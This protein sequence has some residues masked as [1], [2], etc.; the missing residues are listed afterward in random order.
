MFANLSNTSDTKPFSIW[1]IFITVNGIHADV[2]SNLVIN[3]YSGIA[4]VINEQSAS[5]EKLKTNNQSVEEL[6]QAMTEKEKQYN[7]LKEQMAK[8]NQLLGIGLE[9][10]KEK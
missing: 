8:I 3:T 1:T 4:K 2:S 7:D 6:K 9:A 10:K 5:I